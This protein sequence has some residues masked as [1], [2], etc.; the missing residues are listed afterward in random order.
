VFGEPSRLS[1]RFWNLNA[2]SCRDGGNCRVQF[3]ADRDSY[4]YRQQS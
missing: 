2:A 1:G 4:R 3:K